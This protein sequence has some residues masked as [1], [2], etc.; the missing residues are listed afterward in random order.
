MLEIHLQNEKE[1]QKQKEFY[2]L[3]KLKKQE[4][5]LAKAKHLY[6]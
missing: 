1:F 6:S 3:K 5:K 2:E 4:Q